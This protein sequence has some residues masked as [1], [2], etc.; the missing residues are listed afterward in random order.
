VLNGDGGRDSRLVTTVCTDDRSL[1]SVCAEYAAAGRTPSECPD[2]RDRDAVRVARVHE[3]SQVEWVVDLVALG[4]TTIV[5]CAHRELAAS[6]FDQCR[7][8]GPAEWFDAGHRP[9]S[10]GL[11]SVHL[12][13][14]MAIRGGDDVAAAARRC[15]ISE[16]TAARRLA[17]A[18]QLLGARSTGEAVAVVARR[19]DL[20]ATPV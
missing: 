15:H 4:S 5:A 6:I 18:R 12:D 1:A 3:P 14:L 7:R 2:P 10:D 11:Q 8:L 9:V 20:L 17:E 16:R 19:I 13:L